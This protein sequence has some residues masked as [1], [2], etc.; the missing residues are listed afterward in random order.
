MAASRVME[1]GSLVLITGASSGIGRASAVRFAKSGFRVVAIARSRDKLDALAAEVR[2]DSRAKG[3]ALVEAVDASDGEAVLAMAS[4]VLAAHGTPRAIINCAGAGRWLDVEETS[5]EEIQAMMGAPFF[6][7][8]HMCHAF[9]GKMREEKR[10][11]LMHIN[12][13]ACLQPWPGSTGYASARWA[14]RGLHESLRVDL[15][16]SG[17]HSCHVIFGEVTSAYFDTNEGAHDRI[18]AIG[19]ILPKMSPEDCADVLY[20]LAHKPRHEVVEPLAL[21]AL[22][23]SQ[24]VS[25]GLT[26]ALTIRTGRKRG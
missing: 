7:A 4:R 3:S 20:E 14:L 8:F 26:R 25:P 16:K 1:S 5:P 13:P 19:K 11:V 24:N 22:F 23:A 17:V 15:H 2:S 12:S 18:P 10:G 6:A 9:V 21:R